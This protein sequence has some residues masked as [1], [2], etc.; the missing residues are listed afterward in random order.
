M[1]GAKR[2]PSSLV[3][4]TTMRGASVSMPAS[5]RLRITSSPARTPSTPSNLPPVG[6]VSRCDPKA[7]GFRLMSRPGRRAYWVPRASTETV[8]PARLAGVAEPVAH[9]AVL[10]RERQ[11]VDAARRG[12][13]RTRRSPG[14][15][16]RAARRRRA[17]CGS[18]SGSSRPCRFLSRRTPCDKSVVERNAATRRRAPHQQRRCQPDSL[19]PAGGAR[20]WRAAARR[21]S[22]GGRRR[23]SP[24]ALASMLLIPSWS[25]TSAAIRKTFSR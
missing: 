11:P 8:S 21:P 22:T 25:A 5:F 19:T 18:C 14:S 13:R 12:C 20:D 17:D 6:W 23:S 3:Q 4:L 24:S 16:T 10:G 7:I 1:A 15:S 9:P 2:E